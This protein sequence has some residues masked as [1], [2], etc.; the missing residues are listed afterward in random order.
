ME[1]REPEK[2]GS[3]AIDLHPGKEARC[4]TNV[5][6]SGKYPQDHGQVGIERGAQH[7]SLQHP[8]SSTT[9]LRGGAGSVPAYVRVH[10]YLSQQSL[11]SGAC[12]RSA[13]PSASVSLND[14]CRARPFPRFPVCGH[15]CPRYCKISSA[16]LLI[17]QK[18][19]ISEPKG[20][21]LAAPVVPGA[22]A[23]RRRQKDKS[24]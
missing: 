12:Y 2:C 24:R 13:F 19:F 23:Q 9:C 6:S 4:G 5:H 14:S 10:I 3:N 21:R 22:I 11:S 18:D 1:A 16:Q 20:I 7:S 8:R 17:F 15:A